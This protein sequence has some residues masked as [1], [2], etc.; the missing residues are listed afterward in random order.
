[1]RVVFFGSGVF[2]LPTLDWLLQAHEVVLVVS[3]PD[4]PAGRRRVPTPTPIAQRALERGLPLERFESVNEP[5][6]MS[7]LRAADADVWIVIAFG[8][9]L[10]AP[11]LDD[12]IAINLHGSLLPRWRGAA[13]IHHAV[14]AGDSRTGVT[15]ITLADRMDAGDILGQAALDIAASDTTGELHDRLA[16]LGPQVMEEVLAAVGTGRVDARTQDEA[17]VTRAPKLSRA[18]ASLSTA[19]SG[20]RMRRMINGCAPWPGCDAVI[21]GES[22]R[23]LKAGPQQAHPPA[24]VVTR[25]GDVGC[26]EGGLRLMEIKPAGGNAMAFE[27]WA[28]GRRIEWP[29]VFSPA[30]LA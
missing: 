5:A 20:D 22:L 9:K 12:R 3:Q 28:R 17:L 21:A 1:M 15:A 30:G 24:G 2:G 6:A 4:R 27:A 8:Q 29:A 19:M 23:L 18:D 7:T 13:P 26:H 11:L 25:E 14:M 16:S 10:S